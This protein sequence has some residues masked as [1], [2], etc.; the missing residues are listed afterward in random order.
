MSRTAEL[1]P[2]SEKARKRSRTRSVC[3][4]LL[5]LRLG[6]P[7]E[8]L[9][10]CVGVLYKALDP[11]HHGGAPAETHAP[12]GGLLYKALDLHRRALGGGAPRGAGTQCLVHHEGNQT[13]PPRESPSCSVRSKLTPEKKTVRNAREQ[14]GPTERRKVLS[15][16]RHLLRSEQCGILCIPEQVCLLLVVTHVCLLR[17]I[18]EEQLYSF[19]AR[20]KP[21]PRSGL[22]GKPL[23]FHPRYSFQV[24]QLRSQCQNPGNHRAF[25]L[26]QNSVI[27]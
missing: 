26:I 8:A 6:V 25:S 4:R 3:R 13:L 10:P 2:S 24:L 11:R 14:L 22:S 20:R 18:E 19:R 1:A 9:A 16:R 15:R 21:R 5:E 7:A 17:D 27:S 23:A 12:L